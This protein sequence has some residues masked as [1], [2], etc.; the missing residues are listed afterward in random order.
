MTRKNPWIAAVLNLIFYGAGTMYVG[1]RAAFGLVFTLAMLVV[2]YVEVKMKLTNLS[3]E[4]WP[5]F[6]GALAVIQ[7]GC[8]IDGYNEAK[9]INAI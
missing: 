6:V 9:K 3:P 7:V 5:W 8:A 4:M 2:R 1:K